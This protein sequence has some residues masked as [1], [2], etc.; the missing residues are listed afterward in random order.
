MIQVKI[1][2]NKTRLRYPVR[3]V[4]EAAL[5][6]LLQEYPELQISVTEI[7]D[8]AEILK[9][10]QVL[11]SPALVINEKL[12]YDLWIPDKAQVIAWL[13]ETFLGRSL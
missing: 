8:T 7:S 6:S 12:V 2:G 11:V 13:R 1:L 3:R 10:T 4:V 5:A 9:Y